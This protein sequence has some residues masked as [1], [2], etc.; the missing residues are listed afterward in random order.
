MIWSLMWKW[1]WE[2]IRGCAVLCCACSGRFT[3]G[4]FQFRVPCSVHAGEGAWIESGSHVMLM[5]KDPASVS[6]FP[7]DFQQGEPYVMF[8]D[9]PYAHVITDEQSKAESPSTPK[10]RCTSPPGKTLKVGVQ[11][12]KSKFPGTAKCEGTCLARSLSARHS[13]LRLSLCCQSWRLTTTRFW[14]PPVVRKM[15]TSPP[16]R[17]LPLSTYN[18][19]LR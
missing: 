12:L 2:K 18:S 15:R 1:K 6:N 11:N 7:A 19:T 10:V 16:P 14:I 17:N 8:K 4:H 5:P 9:T 3:S 13:P